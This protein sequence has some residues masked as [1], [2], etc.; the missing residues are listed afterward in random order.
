MVPRYND[1]RRC[2]KEFELSFAHAPRTRSSR[3]HD[4]SRRGR[5]Q[6]DL[7][8]AVLD[9]MGVKLGE[10]TVHKDNERKHRHL[11]PR[12]STNAAFVCLVLERLFWRRHGRGG[13]RAN[14]LCVRP[15]GHNDDTDIVAR[16]QVVDAVTKQLVRHC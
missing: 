2:C 7:H 3:C 15:Q 4:G 11:A 14:P 10:L 6:H 8:F 12:Q 13:G 1:V 16:I 9:I 5:N